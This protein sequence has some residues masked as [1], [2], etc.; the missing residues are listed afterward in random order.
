MDVE[1]SGGD[2]YGDVRSAFDNVESYSFNMSEAA[3]ATRKQEKGVT[4]GIP[5]QAL[6]VTIPT[7]LKERLTLDFVNITEQEMVCFV[8]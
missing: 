2:D 4:F 8:S 3:P 1:E 7:K 6:T 5:G